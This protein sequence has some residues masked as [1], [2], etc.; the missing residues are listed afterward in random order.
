VPLSDIVDVSISLS[1]A[2][3]IQAGFGEV[4]IFAADCPAGFTQRVRHYTGPGPTALAQLVTDG[5]AT[6]D[7]TYLAVSAAYAQNPAPTSVAVLR[8]ALKPTQKF[9]ITVTYL[10]GNVYTVTVNGLAASFTG[11][12]NLATTCTG[13]ASAI[14]AL[15]IPDITADGSSGTTVTIIHT[16]AGKWS[17]VKI[18]DQAHLSMVMDATD[19][20]IATDLAAIA[21]EDSTWYGLNTDAWGS[22]AIIAAAAAWVETNQKLYLCQTV[23]TPVVNLTL[24]SGSDIAQTLKTSAYARTGVIYSDDTGNFSGAAWFGSRFPQAPGSEN[25]MFATLAGVAAT[26]LTGT[27]VTNLKAK[28][29]N[30]YY[31]VA[32]VNITANGQ[33]ASG[34][35]IDLTRGRDWLQ[36]RLQTRIFTVLTNTGHKVAFTDQGIA[37][38]EGEVRAMMQEAIAQG[39]LASS[40]V[41]TVTVP[42]ASATL[43]ADRSNRLLKG[44]QFVAQTAGAIDHVTITGNVLS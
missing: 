17:R 23:D 11:V 40:P 7:A 15:S 18:N 21:I 36:S 5:F 32:G 25:W 19:A 9:T 3:P 16:T 4:G 1:S 37:Q 13:I 34:T 39:F 6:T 33:V 20:G 30:Y 35:F 10:V 27:Q 24:S 22:A 14:T 26:N 8:S 38:I 29:A 44:V 2:T 42:L 12:T 28:F 43:A 31:A 41:P